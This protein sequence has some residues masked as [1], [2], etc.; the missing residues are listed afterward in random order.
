MSRLA[1]PHCVSVIDFGIE[2][3]PYLVMDFVTGRTLREVMLS[4]P[5]ALPRRLQDRARSCWRAWRTRTRRGSS[6]A[7]S[8]R[9][10]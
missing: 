5:L 3:A 4:G 6:T 8:S 7:T 9:R 2:G 1:H 10:T